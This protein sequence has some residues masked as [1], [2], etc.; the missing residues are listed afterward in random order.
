M[1]AEKGMSLRCLTRF[2][3]GTKSASTVERGTRFELL[4]LAE[5]TRLSFQLTRS[6][7]ANDLGVDLFGFWYPC[8][9]NI[10]LPK[11]ADY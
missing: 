10:P 9:A 2:S 3:T 6:G 7:G 1:R 11:F 5:L 8:A 4:A